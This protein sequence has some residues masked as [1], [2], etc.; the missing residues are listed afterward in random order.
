MWLKPACTSG[1]NCCEQKRNLR[2]CRT[3]VARWLHPIPRSLY[4]IPEERLIAA[5]YALQQFGGAQGLAELFGWA[6]K[7]DQKT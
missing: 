5:V 3:P 6:V 2:G 4:V 1:R 7:K